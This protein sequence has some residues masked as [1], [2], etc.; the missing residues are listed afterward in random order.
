MHWY[1][2][3][4]NILFLCRLPCS[5]FFLSFL[6]FFS[7]LG[8]FFHHSQIACRRCRRRRRL[9]R[10]PRSESDR[11]SC[12][13]AGWLVANVWIAVRASYGSSCSWC[14][15]G[16][17]DKMHWHLIDT[18]RLHCTDHLMFSF[19][20]CARIDNW[21]DRLLN[22]NKCWHL[23]RHV[24]PIRATIEISFFSRHFHYAIDCTVIYGWFG[25]S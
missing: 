20:N 13:S 22:G 1:F 24:A 11:C 10:W 16:Q 12:R 17:L 9:R 14:S 4:I 8:F 3:I 21:H 6:L 23:R 18:Y 25:I 5:L 2:A 15:N 19:I 7:R